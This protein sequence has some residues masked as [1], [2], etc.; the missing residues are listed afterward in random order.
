MN[1]PFFL[2]AP[3]GI[4]GNDGILVFG[5]MNHLETLDPGVVNRPSRFDR[6]YYFPMP[7]LGEWEMY[8]HH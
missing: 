5:T 2:N 6:K 1:C 3:N 8:C 7:N 4:A